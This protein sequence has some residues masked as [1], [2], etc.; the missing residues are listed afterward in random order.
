MVVRCVRQTLYAHKHAWKNTE[1][2][3]GLTLRCKNQCWLSQ[4][5]VMF[6]Q[7]SQQKTCSETDETYPKP[8][9]LEDKGHF[10]FFLCSSSLSCCLDTYMQRNPAEFEALK[11]KRK[12]LRLFN[13]RVRMKS[14]QRIWEALHSLKNMTFN[15]TPNRRGLW[16]KHTSTRQQN[17]SMV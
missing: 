12:L 6:S 2:W 8:H 13:Y 1:Q 5:R 17:I 4:Y 3:T 16:R 10:F 7:A 15:Y 14:W 9:H 11:R